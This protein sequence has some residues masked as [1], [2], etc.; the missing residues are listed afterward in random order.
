M[1]LRQPHRFAQVRGRAGQHLPAHFFLEIA[2]H[3][4]FGF[5]QRIEHRLFVSPIRFLLLRIGQVDAGADAAEVEQRLQQIGGRAVRERGRFEQRFEIGIA[6]AQ[7]R[8]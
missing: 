1:Q 2:G 4:R 8:R 5:A 7:K 3:G 6:Q